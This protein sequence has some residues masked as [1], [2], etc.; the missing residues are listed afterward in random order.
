MD[1]LATLFQ[2]R[3]NQAGLELA[4]DQIEKF[5]LFLQALKEWNRKFNLTAINDEEEILVKHF[6][7]SLS[8]FLGV[9]SKN[10]QRI[11]KIIDVGSGAGFPGIPL[12]IYQPRFGLTLLEATRK[13]VEFM[14]YVSRKLGFKSSV[15][16]IHGRAE[17]YGRN[18]D[19]RE[20]YDLAVSR[21]VSDLAVL[22]E[23]CLP[24]VKIGGTFISQKGRQV[25]GEIQK[26]AKA[27]EILGGRVN[28]VIPYKLILRERELERT[29]V[30]VDKVERT[31]DDYPRRPGVVVKR[32]IS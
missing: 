12:K 3:A 27:I 1:G 2:R 8:C 29:L 23:Y 5:L 30:V 32:P 19:Y 6:I 14:G 13:K 21:A 18:G 26:A 25:T 22:A 28:K 17:E 24:F 15:E 4:G 31:P 9:P 11:R 7:D 20:K 16:V 10:Y